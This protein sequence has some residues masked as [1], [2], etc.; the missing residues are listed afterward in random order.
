MTRATKYV[1]LDVHQATTVAAVRA[2]TGQVIARTIVPTEP[3]AVTEFVRGMRGTVH[4]AFEEGTQARLRNVMTARS[5]RS[6]S[7]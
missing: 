2:E 1:A 5:S 3:R 4:V 6:M 7:G